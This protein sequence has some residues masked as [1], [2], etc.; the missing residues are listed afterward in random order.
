MP[1]T[2]LCTKTPDAVAGEES[3]SSTSHGPVEVRSLRSHVEQPHSNPCDF[4][5]LQ[6]PIAIRQFASPHVTV[7][8]NDTRASYAAFVRAHPDATLFHSL[9]WCDAVAD[10]FPHQP[11]HL[12]ARRDEQVVGALPLFLVKSRLA[13]RIMVSV[14]YG[15]EG[16][17]L[18]SDDATSAAL[19]A[20]AR[21]LAV[22]HRCCAIEL[23]SRHAAIPD[24][25]V[26]DRYVTFERELPDRAEDVPDWLPRKAR[27]AARQGRDKHGLV[28]DFG[29]HLLPE[30]WKLYA[31]SMRRLA[32]ITYPLRFL[33]RLCSATPHRHGVCVV[34]HQGRPVAGLVT[35][36]FRNRVMPYFVGM[37]DD[38]RRYSAANYLYFITTQRAVEAGFRIFDFGRTRRGNQGSFDFKRF[39]GFEPTPLA[40]QRI[41]LDSKAAP[42]L[43]PTDR[44][45]ALAR[46]LWPLL[47]LRLTTWL[48]SALSRDI[49][50]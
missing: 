4:S 17:I 35:F 43:C 42:R 23:R 22:E 2:M 13:G 37:T 1:D 15:V 20:W 41:S 5:N 39:H 10:S 16:G 27:A 46:R 12:I 36:F 34:R 9:A 21:D 47:P 3:N 6:S 50:G 40:Y 45:F 7:L 26:D 24:S 29:D 8:T 25:P 48:G 19:L 38:A 18:A 32:S 31:R 49:P 11:L 14:P 44:R 30:V 33:N 28:A